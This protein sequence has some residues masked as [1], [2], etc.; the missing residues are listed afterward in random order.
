MV[1]LGTV[2]YLLGVQGWKY[3][4]RGNNFF[5]K[6]NIRGN[7]FFFQNINTGQGLF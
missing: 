6:A 4:I 7:N 1:V 2:H 3:S 5:V